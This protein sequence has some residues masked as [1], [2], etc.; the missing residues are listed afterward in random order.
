MKNHNLNIFTDLDKWARSPPCRYTGEKGTAQFVELKVLLPES[1]SQNIQ[2]T[3]VLKDVTH[4]T[5]PK[6]WALCVNFIN[7]WIKI[8]AT[9][10]LHSRTNTHQPEL[11]GGASVRGGPAWSWV[12]N[13][14]SHWALPRHSWDLRTYPQRKDPQARLWLLHQQLA[15]HTSRSPVPTC[16]PRW[17]QARLGEQGPCITC[18][19]SPI[20][21][22]P[23]SIQTQGGSLGH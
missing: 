21:L 23:W 13:L 12:S 4:K 11:S 1:A 19:W 7:E 22:N 9:R 8:L 16:Q 2:D 15:A 3:G 18:F 14:R 6:I 20:L 17:P 10:Q 5:R